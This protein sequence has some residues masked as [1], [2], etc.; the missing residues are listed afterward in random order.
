MKNEWV[1]KNRKMRKMY[2]NA[3]DEKLKKREIQRDV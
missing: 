2:L 3:D 1:E